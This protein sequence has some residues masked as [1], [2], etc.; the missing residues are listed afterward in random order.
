MSGTGRDVEKGKG[1]RIVK[2]KRRKRCKAMQMRIWWR[3]KRNMT[4]RRGKRNKKWKGSVKE[5][6]R[7]VET[8]MESIGK[9]RMENDIRLCRDDKGKEK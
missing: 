7:R 1:K 4:R 6:K 5:Q 9:A 3:N 2:R 8:G